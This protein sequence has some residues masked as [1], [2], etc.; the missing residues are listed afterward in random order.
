MK[1]I[2]C[3]KCNKYR[4][5]KN[6]KISYIFD[7]ICDKCGSND[8]KL[9]KE[10]KSIQILTILGLIKIWRS[11]KWLYNYFKEKIWLKKT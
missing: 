4:K 9:F 1:K 5:F 11:T 6:P 2:Y 3:I 10:E 7:I 8:E